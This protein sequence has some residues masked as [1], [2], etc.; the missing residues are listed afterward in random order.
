MNYE[1]DAR[2]G[3]DGRNSNVDI[4]EDGGMTE[5]GAECDSEASAYFVCALQFC[6]DSNCSD[7]SSIEE[8]ED[9]DLNDCGTLKDT[10][11]KGYSSQKSCCP[12]CINSYASLLNCS[13]ESEGIG[14]LCPPLEC[15][16]TLVLS[17]DDTAGESGSDA[18]TD[19]ATCESTVAAY[20][21]CMLGNCSSATC[22]FIGSSTDGKFEWYSYMVF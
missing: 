16:G 21:L 15:N 22:D 8:E 6:L 14:F 20:F 19:E 4:I 1:C 18:A 3:G 12:E 7:T 2:G 5:L 9:I 11:C 17:S 13:A 10:V